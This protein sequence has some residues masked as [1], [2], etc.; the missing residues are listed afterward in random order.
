MN[1]A[2]RRPMTLGECDGIRPTTMTGG[3]VKRLE[4]TTDL[5][6]ALRRGL[7]SERFHAFWGTWNSARLIVDAA[8]ETPYPDSGPSTCASYRFGD[9]RHRAY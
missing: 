8:K 7:E 9:D 1:V 3:M 2:Y 6:K 5:V 4:I